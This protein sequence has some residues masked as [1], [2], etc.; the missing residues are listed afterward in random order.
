MELSEISRGHL[1]IKDDD[2]AVTIYGEAFLSGHGSPDFVVYSNTIEKWGS[3]FQ[4][5]I[6]SKLKK[7]EILQFIRDE[8]E[9]RKM[10]VEIE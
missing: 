8:F 1:R 6:I 5:E 3:P 9:R 10:T 7:E 2:H 4:E